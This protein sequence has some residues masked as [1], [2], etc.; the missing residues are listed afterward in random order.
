MLVDAIFDEVR[1]QHSRDAGR[2]DLRILRTAEVALQVAL[3]LPRGRV[4]AQLQRARQASGKLGLSADD[5]KLVSV[6]QH[7]SEVE[8]LA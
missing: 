4:A 6:P 2:A 3:K 1:L 8:R 5:R 7:R